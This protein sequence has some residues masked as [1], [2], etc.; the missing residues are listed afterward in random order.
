MSCR[1]LAEERSV[2]MDRTVVC[3]VL[4]YQVY[5]VLVPLGC[6]VPYLNIVGTSTGTGT[7]VRWAGIGYFVRRY[8][9]VQW[10]VDGQK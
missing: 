7:M 4:L 3:R 9:T 10:K 2:V 8:N 1:T 5:Q 6:T